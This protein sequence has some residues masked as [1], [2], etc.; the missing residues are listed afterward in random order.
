MP[1]ASDHWSAFYTVLG[2]IAYKVI[3]EI[4]T[5]HTLLPASSESVIDRTSSQITGRIEND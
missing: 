1:V 5:I 4:P 2:L 3:Q